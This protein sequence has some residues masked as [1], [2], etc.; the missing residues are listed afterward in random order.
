MKK[1]GSGGED[2]RAFLPAQGVGR[3]E[4][5]I[6]G[7]GESHIT[8]K[9]LLWMIG[10]SIA[11][12]AL[13]LQPLSE[14][15]HCYFPHFATLLFHGLIREGGKCLKVNAAITFNGL[16]VVASQRQVHSLL[17]YMKNSYG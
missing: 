10:R 8:S 5:S 17:L 15:K 2:A 13:R 11:D 4:D 16:D 1:V 12:F 7:G 6:G 3:E 14:Q 9:F